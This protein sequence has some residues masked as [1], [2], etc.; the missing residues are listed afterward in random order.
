MIHDQPELSGLSDS[1]RRVFRRHKHRAEVIGREEANRHQDFAK[2]K[3]AAIARIKEEYSSILGAILVAL[4]VKVAV[5]ALWAW[6]KTK[7]PDTFTGEIPTDEE[8]AS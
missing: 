3:A 7:W 2:A 5:E 6:L 8:G 4:L 1:D